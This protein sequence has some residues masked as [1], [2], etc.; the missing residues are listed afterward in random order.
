MRFNVKVL[1]ERILVTVVAGVRAALVVVLAAVDL[2]VASAEAAEV[3]V[4]VEV[5]QVAGNWLHKVGLGHWHGIYLKRRFF[6]E[7]ML[8]RLA[9][10]ITRSETQHA[11]ELVLAVEAQPPVAEVMSHER[12]LEVFGRLRVWD[13]PHRTGVLLYLNLSLH[14]IEIVADRGVLVQDEVW[15]AVCASLSQSLQKGL[16]EEGLKEAIASIER[17][18]AHACEGLPIDAENALIDKP[19][20]L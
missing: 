9:A 2:V 20:L 8:N 16:Y 18:L 6:T 14:T 3:Q 10:E 13:T 19:V 4:V 7:E 5:H 17:S 11:G 1:A 12:A 15:Q